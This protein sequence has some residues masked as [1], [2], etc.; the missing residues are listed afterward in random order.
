MVIGSI[1]ILDDPSKLFIAPAHDDN[2]YDFN[3][4][5]DDQQNSDKD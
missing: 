5:E 2:S 1:T 3:D 4:E